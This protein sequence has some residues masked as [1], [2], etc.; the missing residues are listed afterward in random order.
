MNES[1]KKIV[2]SDDEKKLES[3]I[4]EDFYRLLISANVPEGLG[5]VAFIDCQHDNGDPCAHQQLVMVHNV[6]I[7]TNDDSPSI[8]SCEVWTC[9]YIGGEIRIR[10]DHNAPFLK[11]AHD[12]IEY[13]RRSWGSG[14]NMEEFA[15]VVD[16]ENHS[17][18]A[19]A[20]ADEM[21]AAL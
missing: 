20:Q 8:S 5:C 21:V 1:T 4:G 2:L 6:L 11:Y 9:A 17:R 13:I 16:M 15:W 7:N 14:W 12:A 10:K 3:E 19:V 18:L